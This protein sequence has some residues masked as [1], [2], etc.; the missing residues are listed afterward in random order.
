MMTV[1]R[2][3][4]PDKPASGDDNSATRPTV[5]DITRWSAVLHP[6][7][8]AIE[9]RAP[10]TR[11]P[12][13]TA[14]VNIVRRFAP[15]EFRKAA[16]EAY[17]LS[18]KA[19][20]V[21][22]VMNGIDPALPRT[23]RL[24]GGASAEDVPRRLRL[25]IDCDPERPGTCS[26]TD[27]EKAA[28]L[29]TGATIR[30]DLRALGWP[31]PLVGDSGNGDHSI[32]GIDL[33]NTPESTA[34]VKGVL[35][36]LAARYDSAEVHVDTVVFDPPRLVK[37][38]GTLSAK[39]EN[40]S[41]R[42]HRYS[43][44]LS[45]PA[46][47]LPVPVELLQSLADEAPKKAP[48]LDLDAEVERKR[49]ES[50]PAESN[51]HAT[52][53]RPDAEAR[54]AKYLAK[55]EPAVSGQGGHDKA[56]KAACKVGPGFDLSEEAAL[57]LL[58]DQYNSRCD[59]EWTEKELRHKVAEAYKVEARRGWLLNA[60]RNG[61][62]VG[63]VG[64]SG[65]DDSK[66]NGLA[67]GSVGSVGT[68]PHESPEFE[69]PPKPIT[70][71]LLEVYPLPKALI[72]APLRGWL[73]DIARRGCF[74]LEYPVAAVLVAL[75][76]ILGRNL[77]IRPKRH[78]TW[79]VVPNLWGAIIG[80]PGL[81]KTPAVEEA[82]MPLK[83]LVALAMEAH[84]EALKRAVEDAAIAEARAGAAKKKLA[85]A[86]KKGASDDDLRRL[87]AET[88]RT[89]E[90]VAPPAKRYMVND[91]TVA[92]LGELHREN[93]RGL[94]QFR[95][96]L[97]GFF[98]AMDQQGHESD[99]GFYLETWTGNGSYTFDRIGRGTVHVDAL[100]LAIFGT[101]QPGPLAKYLKGAASGEEADGF[102]PRFQ[103]LMYPDPIEKFVNVDEWPDTE[104]K[105][106]AFRVFRWIDAINP[107]EMGAELDEDRGLHFL[108]FDDAAQDLFNEWRE[109][110][111]NRLR[112]GGE[113][114]LMACHLAKYRS[115]MP[116]LALLLHVVASVGKLR[117]GPVTVEA[118][119]AAAA[120]CEVLESHARRVYQSA[121]EGDPEA[122]ARLAERIKR[123]LPNP[124]TYR[125]VANKG[126][127]GLDDV[128]SVRKAVGVLEDRGW[129]K[130]VVRPPG[131]QGGRPSEEVWVNP[132][133]QR[134]GVL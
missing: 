99:R 73:T 86:A 26:A 134:E 62:S 93:P 9:I 40:T 31:E 5:D 70:A 8:H 47:L 15:G 29:T 117:I 110:L 115:L 113:S 11:I 119:E 126:W 97:T 102:M 130:V 3:R 22:V 124:F 25:L 52:L 96:E 36:A 67:G 24:K 72:P 23:G 81:Q 13:G 100:C 45:A 39:G 132:S 75:S 12:C 60:E 41:E 4:A 114:P 84:A 63:F 51:G 6:A 82:F 89:D 53:R 109:A 76:I 37:L 133:I 28:A 120:W 33:P 10:E 111:E 56:F 55:C 18:G 2:S 57:R 94:L 7:D 95:D 17:K 46:E 122:A 101:I 112:S 43:R 125:Q 16:T 34:L 48:A 58:R 42:P 49:S 121:V 32:Y 85:E 14:A 68:P 66:I 108:R 116:S 83:R 118:A 20:A 105:N 54:A 127:A 87:L 61:S 80:P 131:P 106:E 65:E 77:T 69:G 74:P 91:A 35:E 59:P 129:V 107:A 78:D 123:P 79:M 44:V 103:I 88:T 98:R 71:E 21:Y 90:A 1:A 104:A 30:A 64:H 50:V 19:P 92:K 27:D 38:Y 128:D